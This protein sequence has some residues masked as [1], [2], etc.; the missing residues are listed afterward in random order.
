MIRHT[1]ETAFTGR[2]TLSRRA[3][4]ATSTGL[5]ALLLAAPAFAADP[6]AAASP[7]A[8]GV[9]EVVVTA[10]KLNATKVLDTPSAIQAISGAQLQKSGV[11]GFLDVAAQIPG[12]SVQDLGPGDR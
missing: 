6:A 2:S 8:T 5:A 9:T 1:R 10:N 4:W 11:V 7:D 3:I 12:L